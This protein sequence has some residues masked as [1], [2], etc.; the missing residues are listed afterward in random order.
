MAAS[1]R[2]GFRHGIDGPALECFAEA[3]HAVVSY[4]SHALP[5]LDR[6]LAA[7]PGLG[8]A[9]ALRGLLHV[10]PARPELLREAAA[11]HAAA[12]AAG[13]ATADEAA[14]LR[15]LDLGLAG[16]QRAAADALDLRLAR[17]PTNLLL[18]KLAN[19]LRFLSGDRV[20]LAGSVARVLPAWA[21]GTP[22]YGY[23]LGCQAFALE[24]LGDYA[25]A[26]WLGREALDWAPDDAWS[27]HA[28]AHAHEMTGRADAGAAWLE[29]VHPAWTGCAGFGFHVAWH[30]A[31]FHLERGDHARVLALYD[32][33]VRPAPTEDVRDVANAVSLLWRLRQDG[34]SVGRRWEELA[35]IARRRLGE[36]E[37]LFATLH[38][39]LALLAVGDLPAAETLVDAVAEEAAG[40][41]DQ[42]AVA[43]RAGLPLAQA[44]L[45]L[46]RGVAPPGLDRL[47]RQLQPLGGSH[48][49]RDVWVRTLARAASE[50]GNRAALDCIRTAR[51]ALRGQDRFDATLDADKGRAA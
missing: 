36:T 30:L 3:T 39:L 29:A 23:V 16:Q 48:A 12:H 35:A 17:N 7:Q 5:A 27:V 2:Y 43:R 50:A 6:A 25:G 22:G 11:A 1:D 34:V 31:L 37:L 38:N 10:L 26:E 9:Q 33:E 20:G 51:R 19:M 47:A 45:A 49:Q 21:P 32:E 14:L 15:A 28:V 8:A 42:S 13:A 18:V 46:A 41:R 40:D 24:E 4:R 44:L